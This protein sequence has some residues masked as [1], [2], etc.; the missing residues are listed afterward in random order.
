MKN[1]TGDSLTLAM[2]R[3]LVKLRAGRLATLNA[4]VVAPIPSHWRRRFVHR[5]NSAALLAE[6]LAGGLRVP[7]AERLVK[8]SRYTLRQSDLGSTERWNNVRRAFRCE[9]VII[10]EM[11]M[12]CW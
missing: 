9:P 12:Y 5:T 11:L 10:Y 6:V 4:G 8:R 1:A 2:G 7:L 3:L